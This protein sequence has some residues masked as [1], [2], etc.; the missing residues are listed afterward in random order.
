LGEFN[1]W[2]IQAD[3]IDI[4]NSILCLEPYTAI[5]D[6]V[7]ETPIPFEIKKLNPDL[8]SKAQ[9]FR[10]VYFYSEK[11]S[12]YPPCWHKSTGSESY[13]IY[14]M[15]SGPAIYLQ[16]FQEKQGAGVR[17]LGTGSLLYESYYLKPGTLD[18]YSA[19]QSLK[20]DYRR[21]KK[22][23]ARKM[24]KRYLPKE[25]EGTEGCK[26]DLG[27]YPLWIGQ[28]GYELLEREENVFIEFPAGHRWKFS[29]L[30]T[31]GA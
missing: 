17:L 11:Y 13:S 14:P 8:F 29:D 30:S 21:L 1:F 3:V 15:E 4:V 9:Y 2:Y 19:P 23:L 10:G 12:V 25:I 31:T 27:K 24:K 20:E 28:N 16:F 26:V 22:I 5:A 6:M 7:Y 18:Y